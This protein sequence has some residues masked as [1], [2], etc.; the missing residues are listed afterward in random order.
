MPSRSTETVVAAKDASPADL[1]MQRMLTQAIYG[2][3]GLVGF[4]KRQPKGVV[5]TFSQR[6]DVLDR[7]TKVSAGGASL[8]DDATIGAY[9]EWLIDRPEIGR[10]DV[11]GFIGV[12]QFGKLFQQLLTLVPGGDQ[13]QAQV[14]Q[15][16]TSVE[17][18][19][20]ALE[21]D[22]GT[23]EGALV[24]PSGVLAIGFDQIKRQLTGAAA[25]APA[26]APA[27]K[28]TP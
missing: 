24:I 1:S 27:A 25:P 21:V 4:V 9:R 20:F 18:I 3:R 15:I 17:P 22:K 6:S 13:M 23:V 7:A 2:S 16:P 28:D 14:P 5:M 26:A 10:A 12:G 19:A 8:A 11:E